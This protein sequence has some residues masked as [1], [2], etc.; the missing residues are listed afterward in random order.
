MIN[1]MKKSYLQK[2]VA[3]KIRFH[4]QAQG[5]SQ[6]KLSE[7]A[8][9]GLK[10]INQIENQN[11]NLSLLTLEKVITALN[12]TPE[13]FFD[14]SSLEGGIP[15]NEQLHLKRLNMKIKQLPQDKQETFLT[16]FETIL[17]NLD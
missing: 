8:G 7:K 4:R 5:L 9:L 14:F 10:Y 13:E 2:Y 3:K 1:M 16:I 6:E 11:H 17:D 12:M 15:S